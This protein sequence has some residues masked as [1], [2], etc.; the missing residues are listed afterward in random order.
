MLSVHVRPN[1]M[2]QFAGWIR[3][4]SARQPASGR[5]DGKHCLTITG[6]VALVND[7]RI[8]AD[9]VLELGLIANVC[10]RAARLIGPAKVTE[11]HLVG[12]LS[13]SHSV[14]RKSL[15]RMLAIGVGR[16]DRF[17]CE[18]LEVVLAARLGLIHRVVAI[19]GAIG[20]N[21]TP[22]DQRSDYKNPEAAPYLSRAGLLLYPGRAILD[23]LRRLAASLAPEFLAFDQRHEFLRSTSHRAVAPT[24]DEIYPENSAMLTPYFVTTLFANGLAAM[25]K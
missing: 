4:S 12:C 22:A 18:T 9:V 23:A 20:R 17:L 19:F 13:P 14:R 21:A 2:I 3:T 16:N 8:G 10:D 25:S 15:D 5:I 7:R 11:F 24:T 1:G 6:K